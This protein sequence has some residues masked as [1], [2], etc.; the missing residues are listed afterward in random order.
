MTHE[1]MYTTTIPRPK[2]AHRLCNIHLITHHQSHMA[3]VDFDVFE[4]LT[5]QG[6]GGVNRG[7]STKLMLTVFL[8]SFTCYHCLYERQDCQH[9]NH[10]RKHSLAASIMWAPGGAC[11]VAIG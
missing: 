3:R 4:P 7:A 2:V 11:V 6:G 9:S 8:S 10:Q 5:P 1:A